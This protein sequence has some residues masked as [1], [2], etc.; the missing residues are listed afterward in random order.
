MKSSYRYPSL[1]GLTM[2]QGAVAVAGAE[3]VTQISIFVGNFHPFLRW[4]SRFSNYKIQTQTYAAHFR[5]INSSLILKRREY[6]VW[7]LAPALD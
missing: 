1:F 2:T 4:L 7:A 5:I 3:E 6:S